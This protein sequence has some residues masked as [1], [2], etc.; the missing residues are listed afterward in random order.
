MEQFRHARRDWVIGDAIATLA[1]V[2]IGAGV[3]SAL[4]RLFESGWFGVAASTLLYALGGGAAFGVL[5]HRVLRGLMP[6]LRLGTWA[7]WTGFGFAAAW[8]AVAFPIPGL[9]PDSPLAAE[10][11]WW[12][13]PWAAIAVG[14]GVGLVVGL[15]QAAGMREWVARPLMWTVGSLA[16]WTP[17][18]ALLWVAAGPVTDIGGPAAMLL[19]ALVVFTAGAVV[20]L[21]QSAFLQRLEMAGDD[22]GVY[23]NQVLGGL[24][25]IDLSE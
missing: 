17:G 3:A 24:G 4:L 9:S 19:A 2:G 12:L 22:G 18:T 5:Q 13:A 11:G 7:G 15:F 14:A 16:A 10:P 20:G 6:F 21:I 25:S 8:L 1:A 23:A